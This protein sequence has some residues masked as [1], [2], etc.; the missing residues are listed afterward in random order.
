MV[1]R[2]PSFSGEQQSCHSRSYWDVRLEKLEKQKEEATSDLFK[3]CSFYFN[4]RTG[5]SVGSHHLTKI[6]Q[7]NGGTVTPHFS[8]KRVS[9]VICT[10]LSSSK[11]TDALTR[12]APGR[13]KKIHYI[14]GQWILDSIQLG[15]LVSE[16]PYCVLPKRKN[17]I[18]DFFKSGNKQSKAD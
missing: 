1:L 15:R 12:N 17:T 9:H 7:R 6:C 3:D 18:K 2:G 4:G 16:Q 13:M 11:T 5:C 10:N 14:T 8:C